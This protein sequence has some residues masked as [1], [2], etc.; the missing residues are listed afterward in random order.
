MVLDSIQ[1]IDKNRE[2]E[3]LIN[4]LKIEKQKKERKQSIS[5]TYII[6]S[7]RVNRITDIP[8]IT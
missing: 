6:G 5:S 4:E 2:T 8:N 7:N 3:E 1:L